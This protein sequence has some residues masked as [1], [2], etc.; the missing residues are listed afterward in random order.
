MSYT[1]KPLTGESLNVANFSSMLT[2][3]FC[4]LVIN[5]WIGGGANWLLSMA[6][7]TINSG[8]STM[9]ERRLTTE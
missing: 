4:T 1:Y 7:A 2:G 3:H 9:I 6:E 5:G 8:F